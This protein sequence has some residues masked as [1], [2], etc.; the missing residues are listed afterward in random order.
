MT[1][2]MRFLNKILLEK[3]EHNHIYSDKEMSTF[4]VNIT[5]NMVKNRKNER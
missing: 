2:N 1:L 5:Q 3:E 4:W